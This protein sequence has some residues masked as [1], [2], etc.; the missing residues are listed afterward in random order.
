MSE[1]TSLV[2]S[3]FVESINIKNYIIQNASYLNTLIEIAIAIKNSIKNNGKLLLCGNGGSA[4]DAQHLATEL[5]VRFRSNVDR[6]SIPAISLAMDTSM[7]TATG[8][9]YRFDEIFARPLSGLGRSGDILLGI[10]TSG[11]SSNVLAAFE[12]AK[13]M[14]I[15]TVGLLGN[16][17]GLASKLC[18]HVFIVPSSI[19]ARIQEIHIT[20]GHIIIELIEDMLIKEGFISKI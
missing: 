3:A 19:T 20:A 10:T 9:D 17:G 16:N 12:L 7:L 6:Q 4:A 2:K 5:L 13:K 11:K 14:N 18:D 1:Y 8:N 15:V